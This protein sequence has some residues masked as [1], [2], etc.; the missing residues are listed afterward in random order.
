VTD[1]HLSRDFG[2]YLTV[3]RNVIHP[4]NQSSSRD[5]VLENIEHEVPDSETWGNI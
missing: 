3:I 2:G 4:Q 5:Q 1:V